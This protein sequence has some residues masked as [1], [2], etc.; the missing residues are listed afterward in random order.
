MKQHLAQEREGAGADDAVGLF[1]VSGYDVADGTQGWGLDNF[2]AGRNE[3][4]EVPAT[5]VTHFL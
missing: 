1:V 4:H 5:S 2:F 3:L